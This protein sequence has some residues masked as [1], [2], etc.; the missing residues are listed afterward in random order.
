MM[1]ELTV[2]IR[3]LAIEKAVGLDGVSVELFKMTYSSHPAVRR[4]LLRIAVCRMG[5]RSAAS[6]PLSWYSTKT[7]GGSDKVSVATTGVSR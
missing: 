5:G 1:E 2:A 6:I 3:S 4:R 7:K